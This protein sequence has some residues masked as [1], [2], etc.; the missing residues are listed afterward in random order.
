MLGALDQTIVA[1][2]MP[3]M[4]DQLHGQGIYA[5]VFAAYFLGATAMVTIAGK[6]SDMFGRKSLYIVSVAVFADQLR[7]IG[8]GRGGKPKDEILKGTALASHL[9]KRARKGSKVEAVLKPTQLLS[10]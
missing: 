9:G 4:V 6:L 7:V 10:V 3:R 8:S 1:T 5:W 2:A